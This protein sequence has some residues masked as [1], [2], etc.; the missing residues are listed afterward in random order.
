M[1]LC[2]GFANLPKKIILMFHRC[3]DAYYCITLCVQV[4]QWVG[5]PS[6]PRASF[7][8]KSPAE[9]VSI[10]AFEAQPR[11]KTHR[12]RE[13][14]ELWRTPKRKRKHRTHDGGNCVPPVKHP[15][16]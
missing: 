1:F 6:E 3:I 5:G 9:R 15:H 4:L 8:E 13:Q 2:F 7:L 14:S 16:G 12:Q 10:A 11:P